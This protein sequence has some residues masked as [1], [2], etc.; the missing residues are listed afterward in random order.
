MALRIIA[1]DQQRI[2]RRHVPAGGKIRRRPL[3][4]NPERDLDLAD[5]GGKAGAST[6]FSILPLHRQALEI[7]AVDMFLICSI[8]YRRG[9]HKP[10]GRCHHATLS[11]SRTCAC[12][13]WCA[14]AVT[15]AGTRPSFRTR[16]C[17]REGPATRG[18]CRWSDSCAA[19]TAERGA[20]PHS[21]W[22]CG[23]GISLK[24][25]RVWNFC[26][27]GEFG[28]EIDC[29]ATEVNQGQGG[30]AEVTRPRGA[31]R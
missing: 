15:H 25:V 13:T 23:L 11:A 27:E 3:R 9:M 18:L 14:R 6:H 26:M 10:D 17:S 22:N 12:S 7:G 1:D 16:R 5:I 28:R 31:T 8:P 24:P 20:G 29:A 19:G 30:V 4:R 21:R 2:G